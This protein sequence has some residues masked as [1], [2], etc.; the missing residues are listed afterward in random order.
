VTICDDGR[1]LNR[2]R[3]WSRALERGL[4]SAPAKHVFLT[5]L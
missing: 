1:G 3:I 5:D 4:A 2:D